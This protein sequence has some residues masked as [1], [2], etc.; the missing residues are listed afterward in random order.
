MPWSTPVAEPLGA[1]VGVAA[2]ELASHYSDKVAKSL[3]LDK[4]TAKLLTTT[5]AHF[6]ASVAT[7]AAINI[8]AGDPVGLGISPVTAGMTSVA[9][10]VTNA[11]IAPKVKR[12]LAS[13]QPRLRL[14]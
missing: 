1:I 3:S 10:G 8:A 5:T 4:Q 12:L 6:A 13:P 2:G 14:R 9:H 7:K 11:Y